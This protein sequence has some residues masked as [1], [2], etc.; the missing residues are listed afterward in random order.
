MATVLILEDEPGWSALLASA[1]RNGDLPDCTVH[2]AETYGEAVRLIERHRFDVALLD[3]ALERS[4]P[5]GARTGLDVASQLRHGRCDAAVFLVTMVDPEKLREQCD[6]LGVILIEKR[7]PDL[8]GE[9]VREIREAFSTGSA[10]PRPFQG[11]AP[12]LSLDSARICL[13]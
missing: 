9:M 3:Y 5:E 6:E 4:G 1:I 2:R 13:R 11:G 8:E 12:H 7:R 10:G